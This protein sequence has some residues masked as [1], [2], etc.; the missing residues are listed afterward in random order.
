MQ[1]E[2]AE[3]KESELDIEGFD[4]EAYVKGVLAGQG[5]EGVLRVEGGLINGN[6]CCAIVGLPGSS[7][8][9]R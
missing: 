1:H 8:H 5:L 9:G 3:V 4:A 7:S 2:E 6:D